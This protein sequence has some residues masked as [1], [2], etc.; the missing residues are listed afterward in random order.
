MT[1]GRSLAAL[2][3]EHPDA[4][5]RR[6]AMSEIER[7]TS[8]GAVGFFVLNPL[9]TEAEAAA[10]AQS[11]NPTASCHMEPCN[12]REIEALLNDW[13]GIQGT[14]SAEGFRLVSAVRCSQF[15]ELRIEACRI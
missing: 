15:L 7:V 11:G 8:R 10:L 13:R 5:A 14:V 2:V 9:M 1:C 3:L 4:D 12:D 6:V